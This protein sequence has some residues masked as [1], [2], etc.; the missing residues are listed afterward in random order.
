MSPRSRKSGEDLSVD[1]GVAGLPEF[2]CS[3]CT[4]FVAAERTRRKRPFFRG[5]LGM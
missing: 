2:S 4:D 3:R 1:D 5:G